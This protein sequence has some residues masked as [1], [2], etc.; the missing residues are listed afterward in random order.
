MRKVKITADVNLTSALGQVRIN[1]EENNLVIDISS[2]SAVIFP[3]RTYLKLKQYAYLSKNI[4]QQIVIKISEEKVMTI[5]NGQ[6][7]YLKKW[8]LA[9]FIFSALISKGL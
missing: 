1:N 2:S 8:W 3:L 7:E 5:T 4:S 6:I 9:K